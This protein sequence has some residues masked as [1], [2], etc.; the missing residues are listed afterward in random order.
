MIRA[1]AMLM[2]MGS[3]A[4]A[5]EWYPPFCCSNGDCAPIAGKRVQATPEGFLIDGKFIV[6]RSQVKDS[7]DGQYHGCF[8]TPE[9]LLCF[10]APPPGS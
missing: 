8:P 5:H 2:L 9:K 10:F 6:P 3:V 7:M 4:G 1:L